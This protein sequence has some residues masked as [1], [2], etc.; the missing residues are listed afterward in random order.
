MRE[1]HGEYLGILDITHPAEVPRQSVGGC[2]FIQDRNGL[3]FPLLE[4]TAFQGKLTFGDPFLDSSVVR[5]V[6][7]H[8]L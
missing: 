6:C 1:Q 7:R 8:F 2:K 4:I 3:Q 5:D